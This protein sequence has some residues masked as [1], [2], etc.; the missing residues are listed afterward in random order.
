MRDWG[1][2]P[3][4]VAVVE[5]LLAASASVAV[6][7][8]GYPHFKVC[9]TFTQIAAALADASPHWL[10]AQPLP[11]RVRLIC[12]SRRFSTD[13]G[14]SAWRSLGTVSLNGSRDTTLRCGAPTC[15]PV[16]LQPEL[17]PDLRGPSCDLRRPPRLPEYLGG[18]AV[19]ALKGRRTK[20]VP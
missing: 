16:P 20:R 1:P 4:W 2:E 12:A 13:W 15:L 19:L 17:W 6:V 10:R 8:G 5:L 14:S 11:S 7:G 9:N 3:H 18:A